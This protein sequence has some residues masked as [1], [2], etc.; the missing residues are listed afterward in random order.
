M[1]RTGGTDEP[2]ARGLS[3]EDLVAGI[4]FAPAREPGVRSAAGRALRPD[5]PDDGAPRSQAITESDDY[6]RPGAG[7]IDRGP[8]PGR[9]R[10]P[11]G[12]GTD[13][14]PPDLHAGGGYATGTPPDDLWVGGR[15]PTVAALPGHE[16]TGRPRRGGRRRAPDG[17]VVAPPPSA[18]ARY[19]MGGAGVAGRG[20]TSA[21]RA[22]HHGVPSAEAR[23]MD[24]YDLG[25]DPRELDLGPAPDDGGSEY[26]AA[27]VPDESFDEPPTRGRRRAVTGDTRRRRWP[28]VAGVAAAAAVAVPIG[29]AVFGG[30]E[31]ETPAAWREGTVAFGASTGGGQP[32]VVAATDAGVALSAPA[33]AQVT[34]QVTGSGSDVTITFGRGTSVAQV[35]G[36]DLPWERTAPAA[37]EPADYSVTAA[38]GSG[39][40]SC[41]ILV[42]G[43]VVSEQSADG[44]YSAVSC[45][46]GR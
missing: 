2:P 39:E 25:Y 42:D 8:R 1:D 13:T 6:G 7:R 23:P 36:A 41:R 19:D 9:R 11:E 3:P 20:D 34:Y 26:P 37:D 44:D 18:G 24:P 4:V 17:D 30:T 14:V 46:G 21:P 5:S 31:D 27:P 40:L 38:G 43:A 32:G 22:G 15:P 35:S 10:A 12:P 33:A 28:W 16:H 29:F 45:N